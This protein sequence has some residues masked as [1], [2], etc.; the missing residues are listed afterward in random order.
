M[1]YSATLLYLFDPRRKC[2]VFHKKNLQGLR[3]YQ[4]G[5]KEVCTLQRLKGLFSTFK[6]RMSARLVHTKH[7]LTGPITNVCTVLY[8]TSSPTCP[9]WS[10]AAGRRHSDMGM[11]ATTVGGEMLRLNDTELIKRHHLDKNDRSCVGR[12]WPVSKKNTCCRS[13]QLLFTPVVN[14]ECA[15]EM[16]CS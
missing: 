14:R 12:T 13:L 10:W 4:N 9:D 3:F 6:E 8:V 5:K 11:C 15:A 16:A 2:K 1:V 7:A